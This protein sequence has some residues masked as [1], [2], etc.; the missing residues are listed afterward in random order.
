[1]PVAVR[2]DRDGPSTAV[3]M[4]LELPNGR[5]VSVEVDMGSNELILD[6]PYAAEVGVELDHPDVR[7][8]GGRD[9][10]G[11][12]YTRW[13]TSLRGVVHVPNA[14]E[15]AQHDPDVQFQKIIYD[16]LVGHAFLQRFAVAFDVPN[17]RFIFSTLSA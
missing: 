5:T 13:F 1:M 10:T 15:L 17:E 7:K 9:E 6:E 11:H 12:E 4:P 3:Y 14:P 16:G 8:V 2:V